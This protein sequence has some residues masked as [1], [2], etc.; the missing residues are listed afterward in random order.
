[1]H[2]APGSIV[3]MKKEARRIFQFGQ[4]TDEDQG[5]ASQVTW[6][7]LPS[8]YFFSVAMLNTLT[9]TNKDVKLSLSNKSPPP[10]C[11]KTFPNSATSWGPTIQT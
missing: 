1:M 6:W 7:K 9:K 11:S 3:I 4:Q 2:E 5:V 8:L 10:K